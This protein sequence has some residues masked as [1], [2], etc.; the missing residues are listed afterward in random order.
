MESDDIHTVSNSNAALL[1]G[2]VVIPMKGTL[3]IVSDMNMN[4]I[5]F[6]EYLLGNPSLSTRRST[7]QSGNLSEV[8]SLLLLLVLSSDVVVVVVL[9]RWRYSQ[10]SFCKHNI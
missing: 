1:V 2:V 9:K 8:F 4:M 7:M 10:H 5:F 3:V 6:V